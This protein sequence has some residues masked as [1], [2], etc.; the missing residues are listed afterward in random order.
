MF[1]GALRLLLGD[2]E[3]TS[4]AD[5][6]DF[7]KDQAVMT[8]FPSRVFIAFGEPVVRY[9]QLGD[10]QDDRD[11]I[12]RRKL[13]CPELD[14]A[15]A[16]AVLG[17]HCEYFTV[18]PAGP[19]GGLVMQSAAEAGVELRSLT[20]EEGSHISDCT[21]LKNGAKIHQ[22][23][24][25]AFNCTPMA[26]KWDKGIISDRVPCWLHSCLSSFVWSD[27]ALA[28]WVKFVDSGTD[29]KRLPEDVLL[30]LELRTAECAVVF[31]ELWTFVKPYVRKLY[32]LILT[33]AETVKIA[34]IIGLNTGSFEALELDQ[35]EHKWTELVDQIRGRLGCTTV[36]VTFPSDDAAVRLVVSHAVGA[37][38]A[39]PVAIS[40]P[41]AHLAKLVHALMHVSHIQ[42]KERLESI[43]SELA[44]AQHPECFTPRTFEEVDREII[45][46]QIISEGREDLVN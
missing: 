19:F 6:D 29:P 30:S 7:P 21:E 38:I 1:S 22:R 33:A 18:I 17:N 26:F 31:S 32:M 36:V 43:V 5:P 16:V 23:L 10:S 24:L 28:S 8:D 15:S 11:V 41:T 44:W 20:G 13:H 45:L 12:L 40:S 27:N 25:S 35:N 37:C 34:A 39:T 2:S 46:K 3:A 4:L 14:M 42:D 9:E